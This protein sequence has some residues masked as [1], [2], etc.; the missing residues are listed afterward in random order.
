[1]KSSYGNNVHTV[2]T[3]LCSG[4]IE[5]IDYSDISFLRFIGISN[6]VFNP[7]YINNKEC[8]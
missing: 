8:I 2:F 4:F 1:M 3:V 7:Q 5:E 6:K